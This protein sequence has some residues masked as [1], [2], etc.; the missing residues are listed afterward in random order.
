MDIRV[1][2]K[3]T[4]LKGHSGGRKG[5]MHGSACEDT[6][7]NACS[8]LAI[9]SRKQL[10]KTFIAISSS[11]SSPGDCAW[12]QIWGPGSSLVRTLCA[13]IP[14][15]PH[16]TKYQIPCVSFVVI[17][18]PQRAIVV[19][20]TTSTQLSGIYDKHHISSTSRSIIVIV[21]IWHLLSWLY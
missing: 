20:I 1:P 4:R 10:C 19:I 8:P 14:L 12:N 11:D 13:P 3:A 7:G 2:P 18:T 15:A 17:D 16:S 9:H 21:I 6:M 5:L